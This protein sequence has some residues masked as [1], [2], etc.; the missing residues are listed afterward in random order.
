MRNLRLSILLIISSLAIIS[1]GAID[2]N[3]IILA[4]YQYQDE[5][6]YSTLLKEKAGEYNLSKDEYSTTI[7]EVK[8]DD[9]NWNELVEIINASKPR[10]FLI[11]MFGP[12]YDMPEPDY[13]IK[14]YYKNNKNESLA[15][16]EAN[17][18]FQFNGWRIINE[19]DKENLYS[20][21]LSIKINSMNK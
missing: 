4:T 12:K 20:I 2:E 5:E 18:M 13:S 7:I 15:F 16:W 3:K 8:I 9:L 21:L 17:S 10:G 14:I 11:E 19:K 6:K 1:C